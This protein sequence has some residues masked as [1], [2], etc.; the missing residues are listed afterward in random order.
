MNLNQWAKTAQTSD[1]ERANLMLKEKQSEE[2]VVMTSWYNVRETI[3]LPYFNGNK[4]LVRVVLEITMAMKDW[5]GSLGWSFKD[6]VFLGINKGTKVVCTK[7]NLGH[8]GH[9]EKLWESYIW[10]R[11]VTMNQSY[12]G[13]YKSVQA[14][15]GLAVLPEDADI[16]KQMTASEALKYL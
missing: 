1:L 14:H 9:V 4:N 3:L 2:E 12:V 15:W 10:F 11:I 6:R 16:S 8:V 13:S 5:L 7:S